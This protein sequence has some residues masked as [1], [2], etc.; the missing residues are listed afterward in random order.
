MARL[1]IASPDA[2][3]HNHHPHHGEHA[4]DRWEVVS[5]MH[6]KEAAHR[7][8][9]GW[10]HH[11]E[12]MFRPAGDR[13]LPIIEGGSVR[14]LPVNMNGQFDRAPEANNEGVHPGWKS[15]EGSNGVKKHHHHGNGYHGQPR[16]FVCR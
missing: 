15:L 9:E 2:R 4:D 6:E 10:K 3:V 16:S 13:L 7:V 8:V 1:G 14:I 5:A 12:E 11:M